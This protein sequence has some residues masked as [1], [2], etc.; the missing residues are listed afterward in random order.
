MCF[1]S[2]T[3]CGLLVCYDIRASTSVMMTEV[4]D[5]Y[6]GSVFVV[7]PW[8]FRLPFNTTSHHYQT[9]SYHRL[10]PLTNFDI[11]ATYLFKSPDNI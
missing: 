10:I 11:K 2:R 3:C 9:A 6:K 8:I 7:W 4:T 1:S 5:I